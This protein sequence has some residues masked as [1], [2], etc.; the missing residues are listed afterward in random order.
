MF[1][2]S[3]R[4]TE[5]CVLV[6]EHVAIESRILHVAR[7]KGGLSTTHPYRGD[8]IRVNQ[9]LAVRAGP[10]QGTRAGVLPQ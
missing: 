9:G 1:R 2:H 10:T 5:A 6:L 7:L 4:F 8:E 3:L